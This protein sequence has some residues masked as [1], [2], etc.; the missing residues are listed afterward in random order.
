MTD[1]RK[2]IIF[3]LVNTEWRQ[4]ILP[5]IPHHSFMDLSIIYAYVP[6]GILEFNRYI[7]TNETLG[8]NQITKDEL[9]ELAFENTRKMLPPSIIPMFEI[10]KNGG[11]TDFPF[12]PELDDGILVI[13]NSIGFFGAVS[14]I[15]EDI[16]FEIS[17]KFES[18][19][20]ILPSSIHEC[21]IVPVYLFKNSD[22]L[23][24]TVR[25]VNKNNVDP[26]DRLSDHIYCYN[27]DSRMLTLI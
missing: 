2:N 17:C 9:F 4:D 11:V 16:L 8:L 12:D 20:Y 13:S 19:L 24:N 25:Y 18:D 5:G 22:D 10:L 6:D 26:I 7:I 14:I 15:Y 21:L 3:Q 27:R 1:A 23:V